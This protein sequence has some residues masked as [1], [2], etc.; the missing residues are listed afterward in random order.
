M[1]RFS[2]MLVDL[3]GTL[4]AT[5]EVSPRVAAAV[6]RVA[7]LIPVSIATGRRTADVKDYARR[8]GLTSPQI[9][10]GGATLID[11][12]SGEYLWNSHLRADIANS[13]IEFLSLRSI[14][15]I[16]THP[17]GDAETVR[18]IKH[19]DLTRISAMDIPESG[20]DELAAMF[21]RE[22]DLY[23]V[24]VYLHYNGWWAV[25]FTAAGV[26]KG[27]AAL[28]LAERLGIDPKEFI[29]AGD[30][31]NDLP[32][33]EIAGL[34]IVMA[35][36]PWVM[37]EIADYVAPPVEEDGLAVAIEEMALPALLSSRD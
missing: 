13:I 34:R 18:Q 8:L 6:A 28:I 22:P 17:G 23:V 36:A 25:D 35:S 19:W 30:S 20:A 9:C 24:K 32:M 37:R 4:M 21:G 16:A 5:D 27:A 3:D 1:P 7:E 31:F 33:L 26:H 11:P 15:F 29:A 12:V 10:N 14:P 2:A